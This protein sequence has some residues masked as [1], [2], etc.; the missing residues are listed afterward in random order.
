M[1]APGHVKFQEPG[2]A[3]EGV[4]FQAGYKAGYPVGFQQGLHHALKV[5]QASTWPPPGAGQSGG[6]RRGFRLGFLEGYTD[7]DVVANEVY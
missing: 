5:R 7:G 4:E 6:F 1:G 3:A 2:P